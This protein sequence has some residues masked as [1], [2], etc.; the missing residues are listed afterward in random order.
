MKK[1]LLISLLFSLALVI[2][3]QNIGGFTEYKKQLFNSTITN[4]PI[5]LLDDSTSYLISD[6]DFKF[7]NGDFHSIHT[8]SIKREYNISIFGKT[9][10][11][12]RN[13]T[14]FGKMDGSFAF[15]SNVNWSH[16]HSNSWLSN[17]YQTVSNIAHNWKKYLYTL[18]GGFIFKIS[19]KISSSLRFTYSPWND[20][21]IWDPRTTITGLNLGVAPSILYSL[22]DKWSFGATYTYSKLKEE[23]LTN[24][25]EQAPEGVV[26]LQ[27]LG[28]GYYNTI[29]DNLYLYDRVGQS[30]ILNLKYKNNESVLYGNIGF[31]TSKNEAQRNIDYIKTNPVVG[32]YTLRK[33]NVSVTNIY[34]SESFYSFN[35]ISL[36]YGF[37]VGDT[38][39]RTNMKNYEVSDMSATYNGRFKWSS[40]RLQLLVDSRLQH[41]T[42]SDK[43]SVRAFDFTDYFNRIVVNKFLDFT[44]FSV[45]SGCGVEANYNISSNLEIVAMERDNKFNKSV[46]PHDYEFFSSS[47]IAPIVN[48]G[49]NSNIYHKPAKF[50]V[51]AKY[52][53]PIDSQSFKYLNSDGYRFFIESRLIINI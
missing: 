12:R 45:F 52:L 47:Y 21:R 3:S 14:I 33:L 40:S 36:F 42:K 8:A 43:L 24:Y 32:E 41:R 4:N 1:I 35:K 30:L 25:K 37:G 44:K 2:H 16:S 23:C 22:N 50:I 10:L 7:T 20:Y 5:L 19:S 28:Y 49:L 48:I 31:S 53:K 17:P 34:N 18:E 11:K 39:D 26:R 13:I 9:K 29:P 38:F 27:M 15:N 6:S 51:S 46:V